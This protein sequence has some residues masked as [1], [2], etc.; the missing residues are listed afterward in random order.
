MASSKGQDTLRLFDK[1]IVNCHN[2][3]QSGKTTHRP[4]QGRIM[5]SPSRRFPRLLDYFVM[6]ALLI[7][8]LAA[9]IF[10]RGPEKRHIPVKTV[11]DKLQLLGGGEIINTGE[12][13]YFTTQDGQSMIACIKCEEISVYW[14]KSPRFETI[15]VVN[16]FDS[17]YEH[18]A[19]K[20]LLQR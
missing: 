5:P 3:D 2:A 13:L 4:F 17:S 12:R 18:Y 19:A 1:A 7:A 9:V 8:L 20:F 11:V 6:G 16:P 14:L 10:G 15:E